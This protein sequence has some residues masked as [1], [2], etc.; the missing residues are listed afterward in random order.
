MLNKIL[1][2]KIKFPLSLR[3]LFPFCH[4]RESGNPSS[5]SLR[6]AKRRSNLKGFSLI[7]LM[8]AVG[9][10]AIAIFGIFHAYS[11][12]FM[13]MADA[14]D[15]TVATNYAREAMEDIKNMDFDKIETTTI[16]IT[17]TKFTKVVI[18]QPSINLKTITTQV[19]WKDRNGNTK[20]VETSMSVH[21]I[22]TTAGT[23]NRIMF[24]ADPYNILTDGTSTLTAVIKDDKGNTVNTWNGD[25]TFSIYSGLGSFEPSVLITSITIT[26][27]TEEKG[28]ARTTFYAS[29]EE[30][31]VTIV[32]SATGLTSDSVTITVTNIDKPVKINLTNWV[33]GEEKLF[34]T[35]GSVS[36]I[37]ATIVNAAGSP[38]AI[39]KEITFS[40]SGPGTLSS[41]TTL[42]DVVG[43]PTGTTTIT[44]T[45]NGTPGTITVT[46]SATDLEP[47]VIDVITG[48]QITLSASLVD[49]P[50][51]ETSVI[52][53]TTKDVNGVPINYKGIIYLVV[54]G[55]AGGSGTLSS[56]SSNFDE[57]TYNLTFNGDNS[58]ETVIFTATSDEGAVNITATDTDAIL[59]DSNTLTLI[60]KEELT[61]Y[62]IEVYAIPTSIP[63]GSTETSTI[64]AKVMTEGNVMITSYN[65]I[66]TF[67]TTAGLFFNEDITITTEDLGVTY[68]DGVATVELY[69]TLDSGTATITVSSDSLFPGST[70]VGFYIG[71]DHIILSAVPQNISAGGQNC[72]VTAK[73]V[74]NN[75]NLISDYNEDIT[76]IISPWPSTIMFLK[77]TTYIL[78]QKVKKGIATVTL[79][80]GIGAGTAVIDAYS[81]D[82]SGTLNIPVG[83]SL[84]LVVDDLSP[85]YSFTDTENIVSFDIDII[86]APFILEEMQVSWELPS[87]EILNRIEV[88]GTPIFYIGDE[89]VDPIGSITY[90]EEDLIKRIAD[91]NVIDVTLPMGTS[92]ITM[93][94]DVDMLGKDITVIFNP[95][96]GDY[97]VNFIVPAPI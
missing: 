43:D 40:V 70:Q 54:V 48:G 32:A 9:I 39:Y 79:I 75:G 89:S 66:I 82:I 6:E 84:T 73:I 69:P 11:A 8:V 30:G 44:L 7:E 42:Y 53:V 41:P 50:F 28:V 58:S 3:G 34:M 72:T 67:T 77:A 63:A 15:R 1:F 86:G 85:A 27:T 14:R 49:V 95:N 47:G 25:I 26:I 5:L 68:V 87:G 71:P 57:T 33:E 96:S 46:A 18:V 62:R 31:E 93:D 83:I 55:S 4:S 22:E 92:L 2:K 61:P 20:M 60:V 38:V 64:T 80:S 78:T 74:D 35:P 36:T 97:S 76:F 10:L 88:N 45:S 59:T 21:F 90:T 52:T 29:S 56:N 94:F 24:I 23:P 13:G 19:Y 12:G 81:G 17:G 91:V 16:P 37:T 65:N 51:K